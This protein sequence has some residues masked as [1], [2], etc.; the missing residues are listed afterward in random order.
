[1]PEMLIV[2]LR[3]EPLLFTLTV[4]VNGPVPRPPLSE[5]IVIQ[6]ALLVAVQMHSSVVTTVVFPVPPAAEKV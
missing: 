5:V 6:P 4:K 2:P 3:D 1:M